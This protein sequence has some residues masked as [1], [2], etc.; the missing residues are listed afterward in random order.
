MMADDRPTAAARRLFALSFLSLFLELMVIRW[1]PASIRLVA[2]FA[3]LMLISS[4]LGIGVGAMLAGRRTELIR[5]FPALLAAD[6]LFLGFCR[7]VLLP[8]SSSELRF[9]ARGVVLTNYAILI[10]VFVLNTALFVPLGEQI[11]R[12]FERLPNLRAYAW[13]LGGS[14]AGTLT[15]G[16]FAVLHFSPQVG[17]AAA[18]LMFAALFPAHARRLRTVGL[19]LLA[20]ALS[21][22]VTERRAIWSAYS[23]LTITSD[24]ELR[25]HWDTPAPVP[26]ADL[27]TMLDP[28]AYILTVNQHFYQYHRTNDLRRFT[29]GTP[30][31]VEADTFR[32]AYQIPY[33]FQPV[34]HRVAVAGGGG[35]LDVEA[36]LLHGAEH[37]DVVEIDPAIVRLARRYSAAGAYANPKVTTHIDDARAFFQ[38]ATPGYDL[39]CFGLLDSHALFSSMAN[40]R[41]DGF[42]YTVE[43][44]RAA[45]RLLT[46]RGVLSLS[47]STAG[48][49]WL[50]GKL[51]RMV[52]EATGAPPRV[53]D[54]RLAWTVLI[55]EKHPIANPPT[56]FGP[57]VPWHPSAVQLSTPIAS[58]DWPYLYL[59]KHTIPSDYSLVIVTLLL[60]S[61]VVVRRIKPAG[62]G[63]EDLHFGA[64]GAGFLL[65]ETKSIV[66]ASLYFGATWIVS[67]I[68]IAGVLL[69]V[70]LANAVASR[71]TG[72]SP[73]LY[74]PL[75]GCILLLFLVPT[76]WILVLPIPGRLL[77]TLLAIPM[78]IFFAGLVFSGTFKR[79]MHPSAAF[80]ANLVGAMVGGFA[81]YLSMA[82]GRRSLVVV[83]IAAY[84]VSFAAMLAVGRRTK[85][86]PTEV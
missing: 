49:P 73:W 69:M 71:G 62:Q 19:L 35:G 14:L 44:I 20:L 40:V 9:T 81:E 50:A 60:L 3:N 51:Y 15:F 77:W 36:A 34:L 58:D 38:R 7:T 63:A 55:A 21:V 48:Q 24:S 42:V 56:A 25:W 23:Y 52:S 67:L 30:R 65:I 53:Y 75:I 2:Y 79:A 16:L 72:F 32:T 83:V 85:A 76:E 41:L 46:E 66:D 61:V 70:L 59:Q 47:F 82:T 12:Q 64:M 8:G 5:W 29:P 74:A 28:P 54:K 43:G 27:M 11:G 10:G 13:D 1:V 80:G 78:P 37:V 45:W 86:V 68:V 57:F 33:A 26:P 18:M 17:L 4:F 22:V 84:M 39:V 6:V 31:Y